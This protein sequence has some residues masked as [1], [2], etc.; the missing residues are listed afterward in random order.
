MRILRR[1]FGRAGSGAVAVLLAGIVCAGAVHNGW[2]DAACDPIP[3]HH[4]HNA[5][6]FTA[7]PSQST[8]PAEHCYLCH[9]LRLLHTGLTARGARSVVTVRSAPFRQIEGLAASSASA[10][11]L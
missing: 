4:D 11:P 3:V 6:R 8:A 5:H 9:S 2:D 1:L 10:L 7:A